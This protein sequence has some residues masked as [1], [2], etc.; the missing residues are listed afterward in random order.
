MKHTSLICVAS[1]DCVLKE[2]VKIRTDSCVKI[3]EDRFDGL[4]L[5]PTQCIH[6]YLLLY[7]LINMYINQSDFQYGRTHPEVL[8]SLLGHVF[9]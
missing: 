9:K 7:P 8:F 3:S 6:V 2:L 1:R 5:V 4:M